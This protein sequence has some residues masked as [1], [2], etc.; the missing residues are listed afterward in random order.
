[1]TELKEFLLD[2]DFDDIELMK[3]IDQ[4]T[5]EKEIPQDDIL[6]EPDPE[7]TLARRIWLQGKRVFGWEGGGVKES[8]GG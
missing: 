4:V 8:L 5:N 1:M 2:F 7:A 6:A 3:E